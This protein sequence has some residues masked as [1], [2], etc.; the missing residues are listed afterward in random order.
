MSSFI[1][2]VIWYNETLLFRFYFRKF[3]LIACN[4]NIL[5]FFYTLALVHHACRMDWK[6]LYFYL[7]YNLITKRSSDQHS[8]L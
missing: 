4:Y 7:S 3:Y 8:V 2:L 1:I 6:L 5:F